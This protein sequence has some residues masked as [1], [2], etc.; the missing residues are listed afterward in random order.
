[1]SRPPPEEEEGQ[2]HHTTD[3]SKLKEGQKIDFD[4]EPKPANNDCKC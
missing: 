2:Q 4:K 1:M 3:P